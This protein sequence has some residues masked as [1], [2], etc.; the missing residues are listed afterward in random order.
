VTASTAAVETPQTSGVRRSGVLELGLR[1]GFL[2]IKQFLRTRESVVF[3]LLFPVM[4]LVLFGAIFTF[5]IAPGIKFS[6]YFISGMIAAG[7]LSVG[8]QSLAI[9]I[10]IE[11]DRGVL[12]RLR[13]TPMPKSVYFLGKIVMVLATGVVETAV[14]LAIAYLFYHLNLPSTAAKWLTFGWVSVLGIT[15]C[16]LCGIAFTSIIR[17]ARGGPAMVTPVA[18]ILQ[19]TSGV[20]FVYTD[21]P[22]V[23][24]RIAALFPLKWMCQGMRSVFLPASFA[25]TEPAGSWELGRVA[26]VLGAWCVGALLVCMLTFRWTTSRDG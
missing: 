7:L 25:S 6:Q 3:T 20:F 14:L 18:L 26:L 15:A 24:Q 22:V 1:Q 4:L 11:R 13:G 10:P 2:E 5:T 16:T 9:Q 12:K 19:F 21:L 23:M 17:S 8:F